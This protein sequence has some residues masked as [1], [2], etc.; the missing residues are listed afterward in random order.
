VPAVDVVVIDRP[1]QPSVG[2][3][4]AVAGPVAAAIANAVASLLGVRVRDLPLTA[5]N[6]ERAMA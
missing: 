3:G 1:D 4:E 6:I 2:A 5:R